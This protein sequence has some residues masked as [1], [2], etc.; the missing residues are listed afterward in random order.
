[1]DFQCASPDRKKRSGTGRSVA[2]GVSGIE[3]AC[4]QTTISLQEGPL[5]EI[6]GKL[7][8]LTVFGIREN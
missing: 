3:D 1:V 4:A 5:S 8:T 2:F 7:G 6:G